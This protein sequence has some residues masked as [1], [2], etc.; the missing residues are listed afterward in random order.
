VSITTPL[1]LQYWANLLATH[2]DQALAGFFLDDISQSFRISYHNFSR[3]LKSAKQNL[4]CA[5]LHPEV[6][7]HYLEEELALQ[8]IAG[9]FQKK[10]VPEAH[11]S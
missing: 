5:I 9:P 10:L 4:D 7:D 2:P 1:L 11:I 6:I 8:C 3:S